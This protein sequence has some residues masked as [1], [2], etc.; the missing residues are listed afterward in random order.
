MS[1]AEYEA[2]NLSSGLR[3]STT[4]SE[5]VSAASVGKHPAAPTPPQLLSL[6]EFAAAAVAQLVLRPELRAIEE[7]QLN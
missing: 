5:P 4:G 7:V 6:F 3:K 2:E 1:V